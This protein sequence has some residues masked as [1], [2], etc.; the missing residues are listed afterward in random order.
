MLSGYEHLIG[1]SCG[2]VASTICCYPFDL[3]RVRFSGNFLANEGNK[4]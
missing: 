2:G 3:L 1:G 4:F